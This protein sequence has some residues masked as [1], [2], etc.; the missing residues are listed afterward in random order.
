[1]DDY[2]SK[3]VR[4]DNLRRALANVP[5]RASPLPL[6]GDMLKIFLSTLG[7]DQ[8]EALTFILRLFEQDV[9]SQIQALAD[10]IAG[11]DRAQVRTEAHRQRGGYLQIGAHALADQCRRLEQLDDAADLDA[12]TRALWDT[13]HRTIEALRRL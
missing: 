9:R 11:G 4:P 7:E 12:T 2:L 10:T 3:P 6:A 8:A 13:Y 1:M 5:D